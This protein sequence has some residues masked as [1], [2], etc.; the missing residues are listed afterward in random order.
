MKIKKMTLSVCAAAALLGAAPLHSQSAYA[1]APAE[2]PVLLK[3]NGYYVLYTSPQAPYI[4]HHNRFMIPLRSISELLGAKVTYNAA[5]KTA[6]IAMDG[7][8]VAYRS[9]SKTL[10]VNGKTSIMDTVPVY[11]RD[12][13]FIPLG[14]LTAGLGI[15][16]RWNQSDKLYTLTG[17]K[18]MSTETIR[19]LEQSG[20][21]EGPANGAAAFVPKF[22]TYDPKK[23]TVTIRSKN[24]SG[25]AV[26]E[27]EEDIHPYFLY[28][29]SVQFDPMERP[30]SAVRK[31]GYRET[32]WTLSPADTG[33]KPEKLLYILA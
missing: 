22:Y 25:A 30:L 8:Q 4:D 32:T 15:Q 7:K 11:Y 12:S 5:D 29:H 6:V 31:N 10:T 19:R 23:K 20:S 28:E 14:T 9:G 21:G 17:D 1:D 26:P 2:T 13:M 3:V 16:S 24:V 27:G 33:G 18:L